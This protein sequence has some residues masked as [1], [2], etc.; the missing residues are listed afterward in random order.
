VREYEGKGQEREEAM[1]EGISWCISQGILKEF[2]EENSSEVMNMLMTEWNWDDAFAVQREEG[3]AK[4][5]EEGKEEIA[6]NALAKGASLEFVQEITG[7]DLETLT[8]LS[9]Q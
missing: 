9:S 5:R 4:G 6:R 3:R 2:L 1:K 8:Q 7:L